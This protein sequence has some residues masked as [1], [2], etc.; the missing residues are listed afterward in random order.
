MNRQCCTAPS[1]GR[2]PSPASACLHQIEH[3]SALA[4]HHSAK[5]NRAEGQS[6]F[7]TS[8]ASPHDGLRSPLP[9]LASIAQ[10]SPGSLDPAHPPASTQTQQ[11][12]SSGPPTPHAPSP[13]RHDE[14]STGTAMTPRTLRPERAA[15]QTAQSS[16]TPAQPSHNRDQRYAPADPQSRD[17]PPDH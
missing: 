14:R 17:F 13:D 9:T 15:E 7:Y 10:T 11:T 12:L 8:P 4:L 1:P 16:P 6:A 2:D 3:A 5:V